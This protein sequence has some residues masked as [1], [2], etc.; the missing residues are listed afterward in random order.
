MIEQKLNKIPTGHWFEFNTYIKLSF[1]KSTYNDSEP[2]IRKILVDENGGSK[3][4]PIGGLNI[5]NLPQ[6]LLDKIFQCIVGEMIDVE[7]L[8]SASFVCQKFLKLS[9]NPLLWQSICYNTWKEK[10]FKRRESIFKLNW[11]QLYFDKPKIKFNGVYIAHYEDVN[12]RPYGIKHDFYY[13]YLRL[14]AD[15]KIWFID[16]TS[17]QPKRIVPILWRDKIFPNPRLEILEGTY[18]LI[19]DKHIRIVIEKEITP[20]WYLPKKLRLSQRLVLRYELHKVDGFIHD[21]LKLLEYNASTR[22]LDTGQIVKSFETSE[23]DLF[24]YMIFSRTIK[25]CRSRSQKQ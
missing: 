18:E 21:F 12:L 20:V 9:Q 2:V 10:A 19:D 17:R 3:L 7:S 4:S 24:S 15:G 11:R 1:K 5:L 13:R 23:D 16:E 22:N 25:K 14:F 8:E 6:E